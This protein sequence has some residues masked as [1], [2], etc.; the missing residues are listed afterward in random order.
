M[1]PICA[2]LRSTATMWME[3]IDLY[4]SRR[5]RQERRAALKADHPT[6]RDA[7]LALAQYFEGRSKALARTPSRVESLAS[8]IGLSKTSDF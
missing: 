3:S 7:H 5:V 2:A 1:K 4:L 6:A 8:L